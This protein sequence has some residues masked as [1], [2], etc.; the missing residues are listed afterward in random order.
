MCPDDEPCIDPSHPR[1]QSLKRR[2]RLV[3]AFKDGIVVP[4]GLMAQGRGEMFDYLLGEETPAP[5]LIAEQAAAA[6][7]LLSKRPVISV[8]GNLAALCPEEIVS[9][10]KATGAVVEVNLFHWTEGR[11]KLIRELLETKG[12]HNVLAEDPD[13]LL[14]GIHHDRAKCHSKCIFSAD[15]VLVPLE[16][17]DRARALVDMGK[18]AISIDLN[19][20]SR[21]TL[22]ATISIVDEVTRALPN[23]VRFSN[24]LA[25]DEKRAG[26]IVASYDNV[27]MLRAIYRQIADRFDKLAKA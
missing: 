8:N 13:A 2:Q 17:G 21:T 11:A 12:A 18:K 25:D 19:P 1:F 7:L 3:S 22:C 4:E 16:D 10:S 24:D 6:L 15:T 27:K 20:L 23:I 9:L 5:A 26:Q 14:D